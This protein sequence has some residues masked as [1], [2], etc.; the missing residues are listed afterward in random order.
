M[1]M[2]RQ[3]KET[4]SREMGTMKKNQIERIKLKIP[5]FVMKNSLNGVKKRLETTE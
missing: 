4:S 1:A 3:E 5:I 2:M